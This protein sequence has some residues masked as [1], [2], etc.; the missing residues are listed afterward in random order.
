MKPNLPSEDKN[1]P[2]DGNQRLSDAMLREHARIGTHADESFLKRLYRMAFATQAAPHSPRGFSRAMVAMSAVAAAV[3]LAVGLM[4]YHG[5]SKGDGTTISDAGS[6]G[7]VGT[8]LATDLPPE[9][10]IGTP[11]PMKVPRLEAEPTTAPRLSV[12][13]G[14]ELLSR[15]KPVTGSNDDPI[16]GSLEMITDGDKNADDGYYIELVEGLQWVQ[17]DLEETADL[18]AVWVWHYHMQRRAYHD[19]IIQISNDPDFKRGVVTLF[20]ND[21]DNSAGMGKGSDNPYVETRFGLL[22]NAKGTPGRY[23]RLYSNGSTSFD[24]NHY[25]EVEVFGVCR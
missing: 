21:Y 25:I 22:V 20:N 15:G 4:W 7:S 13:E 1:T 12:L 2:A 11:A 9:N 17:I 3:A 6:D 23:V 24:T 19:V 16:L 5:F 14:T 8:A 10:F 18:Q